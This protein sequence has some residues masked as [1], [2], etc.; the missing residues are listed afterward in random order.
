MQILPWKNPLVATA[1]IVR[2]RRGGLFIAPA[3]YV[4][5]L[6][7]AGMGVAYWASLP[8]NQGKVRPTLI[9]FMGLMVVQLGIAAIVGG[10]RAAAAI[11]AEVVNKTLDFQRLAAVSS[12]DI[13]F[14][15]LFG[16]TALAYL[17]LFASFPLAVFCW[18]LGLPGLSMPV[19]LLL[20]LN[21]FTTTLLFGAFSL[22]N[23]LV[24]PAGKASGG[25][26]P[27][28]GLMIGLVGMAAFSL[29]QG[30]GLTFFAS[31]WSGALAGLFTPIPA[32]FA[33]GQ[34][35]PWAARLFLYGLE[36]PF[37]LVTPVSQ[38]LIAFLCLHVMARRLENLALP[39]LDKP[40]A[41]AF[42]M[43]I[44]L[45]VAG[46]LHSCRADMP[47]GPRLALFCVLHLLAS[48][49]VLA[50][51]TP[52]RET[53][54]SWIWRFRGR[55]NRLLD[56]WLGDRTLNSLA[57]L[58]CTVLLTAGLLLLA[59]LER[60]PKSWQQEVTLNAGGAVMR[61]AGEILPAALLVAATLLAT[62]GI[63]Y[64]WLLLLAGKYGASL[65]FVAVLIM[66]AAPAALGSNEA[67]LREQAMPENLWLSLSPAVH[68][69]AW[70][71][72]PLAIPSPL[73]LCAVYLPLAL[74]LLVDC[75]RRC[76]RLTA[77]VD[78]RLAAM[79][80]NDLSPPAAQEKSPLDLAAQ[81]A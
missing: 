15:K 22:Q 24:I 68:L 33:L 39:T 12:W 63:L 13:M 73:P 67:R 66:V 53:L 55:R 19:L 50:S 76:A 60:D 26:V 30:G 47:L 37:L 56:E 79:G 6:A 21:L 7:V 2:N 1:F 10:S 64:Q 27:G 17:L 3:I 5:L 35:D 20:Y 25:A 23:T 31:P 54:L 48:M 18:M 75:Y 49:V 36:I 52:T 11:R 4:V 71:G 38:L 8:Q 77:L 41:Y 78:A 81:R 74:V 32:L 28:F 69:I 51:V 40:S 9:F 59:G 57:V 34:G 70:L 44:D 65:F 42:L 58:T 16:E 29:A 80:V 46:V 72:A 45:V 61:E 62:L 14:G 43:T